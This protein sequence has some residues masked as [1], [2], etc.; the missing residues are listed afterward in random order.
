VVAAVVI[1]L[2]LEDS[3]QV[4]QAAAVEEV[5]LLKVQLLEQ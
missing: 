5:K 3:Q 4:D 2:V 1:M